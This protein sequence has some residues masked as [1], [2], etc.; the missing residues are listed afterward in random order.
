MADQ[1]QHM[2]KTEA[3][4]YHQGNSIP[5]FDPNCPK[6]RDEELASLRVYGRGAPKARMPQVEPDVTANRTDLNARIG[7]AIDRIHDLAER[8]ADLRTNVQ[9]AADK[10]V[11][12]QAE[13]PKQPDRGPC[14]SPNTMAAL[15][16]TIALCES[17][18]NDLLEQINR[19]LP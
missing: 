17:R 3:H 2:T 9:E 5:T 12:P 8:I 4:P 6:C 7:Q 19:V 10:L 18:W 14:N 15:D 1:Q 11:G 16:N 13:A